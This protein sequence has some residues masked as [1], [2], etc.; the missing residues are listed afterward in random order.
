MASQTLGY[1]TVYLNLSESGVNTSANTSTISWSLVLADTAGSG[2]IRNETGNASYSVSGSA[3]ASGNFSFYLTA[4][5]SKTIASGSAT[6]SHSS[7]GSGSAYI[8]A[9]VN[10]G[11]SQAGPTYTLSESITLTKIARANS[12]SLASSSLDVGGSQTINISKA[13]SSYTTT[14]T[15][16]CEGATGTIASQTS[17]T[18]VSWTIPDAVENAMTSKTSATCTITAQTYNGSSA[19]GSASKT[20]TVTIPSSYVPAITWGSTTINNAYSSKAV[21]DRSSFTQAYT[22]GVTP[23]ANSATI[24]SYTVEVN[25]GSV[26]SSS[27]SSATT[28]VMPSEASDY[29]AT[30]TITAIDSRGRQSVATRNMGTV[31]AFAAPAVTFVN[32]YRCDSTG[33]KLPEGTYCYV[34]VTIDTS[35]AVTIAK[36][37]VDNVDYNLTYSN[38]AWA[39]IAG[40]GNLLT[41]SRYTLT[42]TVQDQYMA[43]M[44]LGTVT[45]SKTLSTMSLPISLYDD[46]SDYGVT[47]GKI[48]S[49]PGFHVYTGISTIE[50]TGK[51]ESNKWVLAGR[52]DVG[53]PSKYGS[54]CILRSES[55]YNSAYI[56]AYMRGTSYGNASFRAQTETTYAQ[57][58]IGTTFA[59]VDQ[60]A[61]VVQSR[62]EYDSTNSY[63][64][65][66]SR[67]VAY[68]Y[69]SS[70]NYTAASV[71]VYNLYS[72]NRANMTVRNY[73]DNSKEGAYVKAYSLNSLNRAELVANSVGTESNAAYIRV[74]SDGKVEIYGTALYFNGA[75]K[76]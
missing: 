38:G 32:W 50:A 3:S 39:A 75:Q 53:D 30:M 25:K 28:S 7:D 64:R 29:V 5:N 27:T 76:W 73:S 19:V 42:V 51:T 1:G 21:G 18:S 45:A 4:G 71:N 68:R 66:Y 67:I 72:E 44:S 74:S 36:V 46:G 34:K 37:T 33:A 31:Y 61:T 48:A 58:T 17:N 65:S 15:Y 43:D 16:S 12:I 52:Y 10:T 24:S 14:L 23:A 54:Y 13:N 62:M 22:L 70:T 69:I 26:A 6:V 55:S 47:V 60:Y 40:G 8:S 41:T 49:A 11:I 63:W 2:Y 56:N 20:F 35:Y 59:N 9:T 57:S